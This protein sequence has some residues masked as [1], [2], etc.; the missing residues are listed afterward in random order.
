MPDVYY[1]LF[2]LGQDVE[3]WV[4]PIP[5]GKVLL[6]SLVASAA[7]LFEGGGNG[8]R[9]AELGGGDQ[10]ETAAAHAAEVISRG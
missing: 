5:P 1:Y 6:E 10:R 7:A 4:P 8:E 9:G 2:C 3:A